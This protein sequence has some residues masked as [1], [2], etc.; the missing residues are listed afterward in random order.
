[1]AADAVGP[2]YPATP[3]SCTPPPSLLPAS[4]P[5]SGGTDALQLWA[6]E[7]ESLDEWRTRFSGRVEIEHGGLRLVA[8][9]AEYDKQ[10]NTLQLQGAVSL[11]SDTMELGG[12]SARIS[13]TDQAGELREGRYRYLD[14]NA[15]GEAERIVLRSGQR[16]TMKGLTFTTCPPHAVDWHIKA[17]ELSLNSA[18]NTGELYR[19]TFYVKQIPV[20]YLPYL[21]FPLQGRKSGF[22]L[23]SYRYSDRSGTDFQI[24]YYWNLAPNYDA[25]TT[26]RQMTE[27]GTML[28]TELR[29][30]DRRQAGEVYYEHLWD[31]QHYNTDRFYGGITHQLNFARG[32]SS[33][34]DYHEVS[35]N[36]YFLDIEGGRFDRSET[37]LNQSWALNYRARNWELG[38]RLQRFQSLDNEQHYR[39]WPGLQAQLFDTNAANRL[40]Y[41]LYAEAS[42]FE[43]DDPAAVTGTRTTI[44]PSLSLPW[45]GSAGYIE[46]AVT[47][48]HTEYSLENQTPAQISRSIP[49]SSIDAGLFFER[50]TQLGGQAL[51]QT[52]EPRLY[53]LQVP[54][55][56]QDAI[57]LF[58]TAS[59]ETSLASLFRPNRFSGQDR[60]GDTEQL[61][62]ALTTRLL[63]AANG[64]ELLSLGVGQSLYFRD[65]QVTLQASDP[66]ETR[67][68]SDVV[69]ELAS[70]P[71]EGLRLGVT[72]S[73]DP[74]QERER[75]LIGR[76]RYRNDSGGYFSSRYTYRRD[77]GLRQAEALLLWPLG[78]RWRMLAGSHYDLEQEQYLEN[79]TG[80]EYRSCCWAARLVGREQYNPTIDDME[81]SVLLTVELTG[82]GHMGERLE[83]AAGHGMLDDY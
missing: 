55:E 53:Y 80:L 63:D 27:R 31:D 7:A 60:V 25:T 32:W 30:L 22:L 26:I 2:A 16:A 10:S 76:L 6:D 75:V 58:D 9:Q 14:A 78:E 4:E 69:A 74:D 40:H 70:E 52:L 41:G 34:I 66:V 77:N 3:A 21:N 67:E 71:R 42:Q 79:V 33:E 45:R 29:Y 48:H 23:P 19:A 37:Q 59:Y 50:D 18:T 81:H 11:R 47:L 46:P 72:A 61:S 20:F 1:M 5:G 51:V 24:P 83:Q 73:W 35:D 8:E 36:D 65:R 49:I 82:L 13:M 68:Y 38:T 39:L 28:G 12:S 15:S 43:H 64:R 44:Q 54:Y 17:D 57:P 56:A 62:L